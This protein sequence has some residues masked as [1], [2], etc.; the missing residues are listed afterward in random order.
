MIA[1]R[2]TEDEFIE[3]WQRYKSATAVARVMG[4]DIRGVHERRRRIESKR[5]VLL[6]AESGVRPTIVKEGAQH[7]LTVAAGNVVVFS[8]VHRWPGDRPSLAETGLLHVLDTLPNLKAVVCN[9]DLFDGARVSRHGPTEWMDLPNV[10]DELEACQAF[11]TQIEERVPDDV[12]LL[13]NAGN[14]DSRFSVKISTHLPELAGVHGTDLKDHFSDRWSM[15]WST[16]VN[17]RSVGGACLIKHRFRGGIHATWNNTLHAGV[18]TV[19]GHLH[20][21]K[22]TPITDINGRRWG[23]DTG[24]L[25]RFKGEAKFGYTENNPVNWAEGFAV[26]TWDH[27]GRMAPPSLAEVTGDVCWFRGEAIASE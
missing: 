13:W 1:S 2:F 12:P 21:C 3:L 9:G 20:Q 4:V 25:S 14:H 10:A 6:E 5:G 19:T 8:D 15:A 23:V 26:L 16:M 7:E 17:A 22:V 27:E 24:T 18:S 11:M